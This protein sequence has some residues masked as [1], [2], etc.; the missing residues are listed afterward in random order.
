MLFLVVNL[1]REI[2]YGFLSMTVLV[3]ASKGKKPMKHYPQFQ[4]ISEVKFL[5]WISIL[6]LYPFLHIFACHH[7]C[8]KI[9]NMLRQQ[10]LYNP[11][12][13][14][15]ICG[16]STYFPWRLKLF[17]TMCYLPYMQVTLTQ[18]QLALQ[19]VVCLIYM[20]TI[21]VFRKWCEILIS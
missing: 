15:I 6:T 12:R 10:D 18:V 16:T 21:Y 11:L 3:Q 7:Y 19:V 1:E 20:R 2:V 4:F 5:I 17:K 9:L 13:D 8:R 14:N